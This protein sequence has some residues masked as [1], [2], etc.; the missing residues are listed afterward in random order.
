[1]NIFQEKSISE[2]WG[3]VYISLLDENNNSIQNS[4]IGKTLEM[5]KTC[6][7]VENSRDRWIVNRKPMI[8]P[9]FAIAEIFWI[10]DGSDESAF[11]NQWNPLMKKYAGDDKKY[12]GAYGQ[13]L[14]HHLGFDQIQR[15][16]ETLK[17]NP[18]SRQ[19]VL[20]IWDGKKDLPF[21]EG[22]PNS[23]DIPCNTTSLL[24]IR[25]NKLEWS[26]IMRGN[27]LFRGTPYNFIQFSTLQEIMAGWLDIEIG[28]YFYF[29]DSLHVYE[30]DMKIFS[31][32]EETI[33][34]NNSDKLLFSKNQFDEFFPKC[35]NILK[36][37]YKNGLEN[38][39][40]VYLQNDKVIPQEYKNLLSLPLAYI[41]LKNKQLNLLKISEEIC[42]NTLLLTI[43]TLWKKEHSK[44]N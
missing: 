27:D 31:K 13:R 34:S 26:Q 38:K 16:Y 43:W 22:K 44:K 33:I 12:Y 32:R 37:V 17:N 40:I 24:K 9:A 10:L 6:I 30:T 41:A 3:K 28:E 39:D 21:T 35:M 25:D 2:V 20:Q 8:S 36:K 7:S 18:E 14:K 29:S 19:V 11:I 42:T 1:M 15:A 5:M 23:T 4:R